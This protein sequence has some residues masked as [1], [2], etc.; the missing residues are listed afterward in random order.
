M[1]SAVLF[2]GDCFDVP[3]M[4]EKLLGPLSL[5][6]IVAAR[7]ARRKA[8]ATGTPAEEQRK[9]NLSQRLAK[10]FEGGIY[11]RHRQVSVH[12]LR[13]TG[14]AGVGV[15]DVDASFAQLADRPAK[16]SGLIA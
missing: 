8:G 4:L 13:A 6:G 1:V 14:G 2:F 5:A 12:L 7:L 11:V 16:S 10:R 15:S 3:P 9:G